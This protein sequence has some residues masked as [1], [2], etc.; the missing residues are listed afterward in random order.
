MCERRVCINVMVILQIT[1]QNPYG[2]VVLAIQESGD[3]SWVLSK[4][5]RGI[6]S[7]ND[8]IGKNYEL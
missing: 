2:L 3:R 8:I 1:C 6:D 7:A 5:N 4:R